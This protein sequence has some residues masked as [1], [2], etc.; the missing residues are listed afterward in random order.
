MIFTQKNEYSAVLDACVLVPA[1]LNDLLL[2]LAE[3]P[4]MYRPLW[5]EQILTEMTTAM[6][7][8]LHRTATEV[9]YRKDQM[10]EAFP[11]AM[12]TVPA[13][14]LRAVDCLPDEN[15]RHVLAAAIM[16]RANTIVTQNTKH[17]PNEC[18]DKFRVLCQTADDFLIHQY[19]LSPQLLLDKLDDQAA[20]IAQNRAY[21]IAS[22]K[23][24][25]KEFG[26]LVEAHVL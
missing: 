18:L 4:A 23:R 2:R 12:V 20:G 16:A 22:L 7:T 19:H 15:D 14:L 13:E 17:F 6:K 9:A 1:A 3:E 21:V 5:S 11:E 8:K 26:K 24:S 10:C 25:A